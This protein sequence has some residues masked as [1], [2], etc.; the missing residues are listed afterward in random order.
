MEH[1]EKT[2]WKLSYICFCWGIQ[3][4]FM[5]SWV[6]KWNHLR[7]SDFVFFATSGTP[8]DI[9][10]PFHVRV[11]AIFA[12]FM[13][14]KSKKLWKLRCSVFK[15]FFRHR[16]WILRAEK[17]LE[18][19]GISIMGSKIM[20]FRFSQCHVQ[21]FTVSKGIPNKTS[22]ILKISWHFVR[23]NLWRLRSHRE[24]EIC[25]WKLFEKK[26]T[27]LNCPEISTRKR[28]PYWCSIFFE[29]SSR[30]PYDHIYCSP[31]LSIRLRWKAVVK[32]K[33]TWGIRI[34]YFSDIRDP[35]GPYLT[36]SCPG[37]RNLYRFHV[38][39]LPKTVKTTLF[40]AQIIF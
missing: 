21:I 38:R 36:V 7:N 4:I 33:I 11:P 27:H 13:S 1:L 6:P 15:A 20:I 18:L 30:K 3:P 29:N 10:W 2:I 32:S 14:E 9:I 37:S 26:A 34:S 35:F 39:E 23:K 25:T 24:F 16:K 8:S 17:P 12:I 22:E 28:K 5:Q 31:G 19:V 40:R